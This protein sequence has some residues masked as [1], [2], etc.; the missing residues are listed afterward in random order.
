MNECLNHKNSVFHCPNI[1]RET[2]LN[3]YNLVLLSTFNYINEC[4]ILH[5]RYKKYLVKIIVNKY[6]LWKLQV[7]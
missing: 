2:R 3:I 5:F 6:Y 4:G 7:I 1:L